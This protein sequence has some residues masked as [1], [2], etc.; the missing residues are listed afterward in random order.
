[1]PGGHRTQL[2]APSAENKPAAHGKQFAAPGPEKDPAAQFEQ[3][4][5]FVEP[6]VA[7][8]VPATQR[9]QEAPPA[10]ENDP[11]AQAMQEGMTLPAHAHVPSS[12]DFASVATPKEPGVVHVKV[13]EEVPAVSN[14]GETA[15]FGKAA[16]YTESSGCE[17][18]TIS[19]NANDLL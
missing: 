6:L 4:E 19:C 10:V 12:A 13:K 3:A 5:E 15:E 14:E 16:R 18:D 9:V 1:M 7:E 8:Y 17:S 2:A 11:A